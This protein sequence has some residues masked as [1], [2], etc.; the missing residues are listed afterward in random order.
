MIYVSIILSTGCQTCSVFASE[1]PVLYNFIC[2]K[3]RLPIYIIYD[4]LSHEWIP[5]Y[6]KNNIASELP[7]ISIIVDDNVLCTKC[8][9]SDVEILVSWFQNQLEIYTNLQ[10][11]YCKLDTK[12]FA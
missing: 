1:S 12:S 2:S 9:T 10:S 7:I 6:K 8:G 11:A 4:N 5:D 3:L